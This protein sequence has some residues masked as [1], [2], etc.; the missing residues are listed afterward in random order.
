MP[1]NS[2]E[3]FVF[4]YLA[5]SRLIPNIRCRYHRQTTSSGVAIWK[6]VAAN[7]VVDPL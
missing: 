5:A 3:R 1:A 6:V 7:K 4:T 2:E